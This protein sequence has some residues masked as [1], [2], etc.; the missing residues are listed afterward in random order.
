MWKNIICRFGIPRTVIIENGQQFDNQG[1]RDCCL[2][3]GIKNQFS[4][5]GHPQA[6]GQTE[7]TIWTLLKIIKAKLD[8]TKGAWPEE[9]PNVL[10][11]Y[12]TTV[13]TPTGETPFRFT[14]GTEVVILVEVGVTSIRRETFNEKGNDDELR[15]NLDCLDEVRDKTS[16]K[17]TKYQ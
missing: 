8:D 7:V 2:G 11:A 6:N 1:F 5:P 4:S 14:Y 3:L 17:M 13:R 9:L 15:L 12:R 10:W 16:S